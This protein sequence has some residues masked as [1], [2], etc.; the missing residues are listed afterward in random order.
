M[1]FEDITGQSENPMIAA[2]LDNNLQC[3]QLLYK[4]GYRI[5]LAEED[6][7]A[8]RSSMEVPESE[9]GAADSDPDPLKDPVVR[10]LHFK[11]YT[12]PLYLSID[13][14]ERDTNRSIGNLMSE[15]PIKRA[16]ALGQRAKLL[17]EHFPEHWVEYMNMREQLKTY[18]KDLLGQCNNS[19]EVE[20]LLKYSPKAQGRKDPLF[21]WALSEEQKLFVA[22]PYY[23]Q[24]LRQSLQAG[25]RHSST[26]SFTTK[27]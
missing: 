16:F 14:V 25:M 23:Q 24:F 21:I 27:C 22:H 19:Q 2:S 6:A 1:S 13:M 12:N 7:N 18:A 20:I 5:H 15:D 10:F 26:S 11:A 4:A 3:M 8:V 9:T 17:A